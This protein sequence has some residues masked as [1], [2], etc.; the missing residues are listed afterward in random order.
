MP[1][2]QFSF[3]RFSAVSLLCAGV[4]TFICMSV[5]ASR[6]ISQKDARD[7]VIVSAIASVGFTL[8]S[9]YNW[10]VGRVS[11]RSLV[12][13]KKSQPSSYRLAMIG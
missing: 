9:V 7:M 13:E 3:H 10:K 11:I 8:W 1:N 6:I 5:V 2:H 12:I 4:V